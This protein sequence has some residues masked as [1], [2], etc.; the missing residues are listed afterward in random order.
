MRQAYAPSSL[1]SYTLP[2]TAREGSDKSGRPRLSTDLSFDYNDASAYPPPFSS[3]GF[4]FPMTTSS[5]Y[6]RSTHLSPY[7]DSDHWT[8]SPSGIVRPSST[9]GGSAHS[10]PGMKYEDGAL[11]HSSFSAPMSHAQ[12][13]AGSARISGHHH[14]SADEP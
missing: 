10:S 6:Q 12:M 13:F 1:S 9:P 5:D 11:R 8:S 3:T 7:T 2:P 14:P 4:G